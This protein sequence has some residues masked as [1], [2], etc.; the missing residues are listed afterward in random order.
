M[1][2]IN[3]ILNSLT[4]SN[5]I[6]CFLGCV[7]GTLVGV[8]PGVGPTATLAILLPVTMYLEPTG[9]IIMLAGI[10]YGAQYGGS[11]TSILLNIPG[12]ISSAPTCFDGFPMTKQGRAGEALWIAAVGSFIA[13][14]LSCVGLS[15][16]G[17]GLAKYAL[18]FG[19]PEKFGLILF[20]L[21]T[22]ISFSGKSILRGFGIGLIGIILSTVGVDQLTGVTRF[23]Y[24]S[25]GMM[26]GFDLASMAVGLFGI[27][28]VLFSAEAGVGKIFEGKLGKMTPRGE[29]LK[30]GLR[31]SIRGTALGFPLGLI[32]GII[33]ALIAFLSYDLEKRVSKYPEKFGTGVIEG[34]AGPESA[35]NATATAN[36]VP[37]MALGIPAGPAMAL[38]LASFM[39]Y[40]LQPGPMLFQTNKEFVWT[41][42]GSMYV[43]NVMLLILNLPLVGLWARI[44]LIPYKFLGPTILGICIIAAYSSRN[45][46]FDLWIALG[47]GVL[48]YIMKKKDWPVAPLILGLILGPMLEQALRQSMSI[49]GPMIFF[50]RPISVVFLLLAIISTVAS[51]KY[52]KRVPNVIF[53]EDSD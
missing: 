30:K 13:G 49:G 38:L 50:H 9:S 43:G 44:S 20:S 8:L 21:T 11:T 1:D 6:Y 28:E 36:F 51:L 34:V 15:I 40:G 17:P 33:P 22:I 35:N 10:Y 24:G 12:E 5:L 4:T 48:G 26:R 7:M 19:P 25:I 18:N 29:E 39:I 53:E 16:V 31:A 14:T 45:I 46:M 41:L 37:L 3:G 52:L 27:G 32:P 42:I 2:L 47:A 23:S